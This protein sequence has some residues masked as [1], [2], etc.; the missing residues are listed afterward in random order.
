MTQPDDQDATALQLLAS[1]GRALAT[2]EI[3]DSTLAAAREIVSAGTSANT[4]R[5]YAT[6]IA[7]W[8][9]WAL[10]RLDLVDLQPPVPVDVVL[11]FITDHVERTTADGSRT[12]ELPAA[13]DRQ[14]VAI[15][16]K[17]A[18]GA[19]RVTTVQHRVA[20]L[21][22]WHQQ[23]AL[24]NGV[25]EHEYPNP[26]HSAA[27]RH[28]L[29]SARRAA[30]K[31]EKPRRRSA[32]TRS[33]LDAVLDT[34]SDP[35]SL[36]DL[37]DRAIL[38]VGWASGGRRRSELANLAVDQLRLEDAET[39]LW[40]LGPTKTDQA[41]DQDTPDKPIRGRAALALRA[42]LARSMITEGRVFRNVRGQRIGVPLSDR[43]IAE[44]VKR[45]AKL[46]GLSDP[47]MLWGG[48]SLRSGF[49]TEATR[50]DVPPSE[51]MDMT[52]HRSMAT[53]F[54]YQRA[55]GVLK[56]KASRLAD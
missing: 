26:A 49:V 21:S 7:Y 54:K 56:S 3:A 55:A 11:T 30:A 37:R 8:R 45:R 47:S 25:P 18:P 33:F 29:S 15:G 52:D 20:M 41:D 46:A 10:A 31:T 43:A 13:V 19:L 51:I 36:L 17:A 50:S 42:W 27:V 44:I 9:A 22:T 16:A 39:Y 40:Q 24:A 28:L 6:A 48:H 34:C 5:A 32:L 23:Q 35:T 14:L 38:L 4:R 53:L 1:S 12:H 2:A